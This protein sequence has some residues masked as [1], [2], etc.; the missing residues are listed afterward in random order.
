MSNNL[1]CVITSS[2]VGL[3]LGGCIGAG[4]VFQYMDFSYFKIYKTNIGMIVF[5]KDKIYN[6]NE[7]K[8]M[9]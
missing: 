6:L 3:L 9:E 7:M 5:V 1:K 2:L 8:S 4:A